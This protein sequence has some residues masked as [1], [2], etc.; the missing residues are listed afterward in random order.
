MPKKI[1]RRCGLLLLGLILC[2]CGD[3]RQP[4]S[5]D[6]N[7]N[8]MGTAFTVT[9]VAPPASLELD[10]LRESILQ[11]LDDIE[12]IAST[13]RSNSQLSRFNAN[14]SADWIDVTPEFCAMVAAAQAVSRE[15]RGAFDITVQPLV[16]LWGFGPATRLSGVPSTE[17]IET[18]L[19]R[20]GYEK[21][22]TDC[23]RS[24]LRKTDLGV[25]LDLSAWAKGYA[26]DE[27]TELL[28]ALQLTNYL[29]EIGGELRLSG[30]NSEQKK[31]A[32]GIAEPAHSGDRSHTIVRLTDVAIATSGDY[33]NFY[34]LDGRRY[35]HAIDPRSGR[36][37]E[38]ALTG[39]TVINVS[40]AH[41]DAW[42]TALLVLGPDEGLRLAQESGIA[43]YFLLRTENGI[44]ESSTSQ[45]ERLRQP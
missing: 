37:I 17:E 32:I 2:A 6:L 35:S 41:A 39:V 11:R 12:D 42:A 16:D 14:Q 36:P 3:T 25:S 10:L 27:L 21:L 34:E 44:E 26:V 22:Q 29:V 5:Y 20:V 13:Y 45:F 43:A 9:V 7:G 1:A 38:H 33:N 18:V 24:V 15:T 30:H 40:T 28:D 19:G 23:E 8:A 4:P 31:F